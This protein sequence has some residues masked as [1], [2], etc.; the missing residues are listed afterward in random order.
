[1][2]KSKKFKATVEKTKNIFEAY[3]HIEEIISKEDADDYVQI[4]GETKKHT[5]TIYGKNAANRSQSLA[6]QINRL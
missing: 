1:M 2:K 5:L 6:D 3:L 4:E